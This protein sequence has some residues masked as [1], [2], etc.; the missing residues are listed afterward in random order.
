MSHS[1][2]K[3]LPPVERRRDGSLYCMN[4]AQHKQAKA[5][6]AMNAVITRM[7]IASCWMMVTAILVLSAFPVPLAVSGLGMRFCP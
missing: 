3:N 2:H 5:L 7:E 1:I 4:P 6:N